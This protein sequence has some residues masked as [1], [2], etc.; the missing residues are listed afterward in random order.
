DR[1]ERLIVSIGRLQ[2]ANP[3]FSQPRPAD[4]YRIRVAIDSQDL[5][6]FGPE[7]GRVSPAA[8]GCVDC[9]ARAL[10]GL[11]HWTGQNRNVIGGILSHAGPAKATNETPHSRSKWGVQ[12]EFERG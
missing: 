9:P 3:V 5:Y 10:R 4:R 7:H 2:V 6:A 8:E 1:I 12:S 11:D